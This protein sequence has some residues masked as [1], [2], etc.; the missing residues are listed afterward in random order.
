MGTD[1]DDGSGDLVRAVAP[2]LLRT[3]VLLT[4]D[5]RTGEDLLVAA[6]VRARGRW[7]TVRTADDPVALVRG[8]LV[9]R[10]L[11]RPFLGGEQVLESLPD[12]D[13]PTAALREGAVGVAQE[14]RSGGRGARWVATDVLRELQRRAPR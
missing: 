4:G 7:R 5:R 13:A 8:V 14:L 10:H 2:R 12:P 6:L 11:R 9:E 1:R 3:A